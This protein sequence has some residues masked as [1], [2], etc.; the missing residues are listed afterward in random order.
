MQQDGNDHSMF[1]QYLLGQVSGAGRDQFE[2]KLFSDNEFFEELLATE[3]ELIEAAIGKELT[4]AEADQFE[5]QFLIIPD[6][7]E[8]L[9]FRRALQRVAKK[10]QLPEE[11]RAKAVPSVQNWI[12]QVAVSLVA[13]V[14]IGGIIWMLLPRTIGERTLIA[15]ANERGGGPAAESVSLP[16]PYD[17]LKLH[18]TLPQPAIPAKDY[19]VEMRSADGQIWVL[20]VTAYNEQFVDVL[21]PAS[22]LT[23]GNYALKVSV[24]KPDST[25]QTFHYSYLLSVE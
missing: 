11:A 15:A 20:K 21:I 18:L 3:D 13:L 5:K 19:R 6:R 2:G 9:Q 7:K 14:I 10:K 24:I 23:R 16:L 4:A 17:D 8:K 1:R 22:S 12:L 25:V